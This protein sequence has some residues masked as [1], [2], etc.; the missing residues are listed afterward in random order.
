M[1]TS[2]RMYITASPD[3]C[4]TPRIND[5]NDTETEGMQ[6]K[7]TSTNDE[8]LVHLPRVTVYAS[9]FEKFTSTAGE[10][11]IYTCTVPEVSSIDIHYCSLGRNQVL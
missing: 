10:S 5:S 11:V 8:K 2:S 3:Q 4:Q 7:P 6:Q 9:T 1:I